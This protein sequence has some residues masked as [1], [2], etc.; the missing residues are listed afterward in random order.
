M[1]LI[2]SGNGRVGRLVASALVQQGDSVRVFVRDE[3]GARS[4]FGVAAQIC[5]GDL[6]D[7]ASLT[8]AMAGVDSVLLCTPVS[9]DMVRQQRAVINAAV[10][11]SKPYLVK[12]SGLAT[13]PGSFVDSGRWHAEIEA[14]LADSGLGYTCL[15]P[16]FFMQN[17][18]FQ[19][20]QVRS[21]GVLRSG[22]PTAPI[23]MVDAR[24]IAAVAVK[25]LCDP[26]LAPGQTLPLTT[27]TALTYAAMAQIMSSVLGQAVRYE[28]QDMAQIEHN[29]RQADQPE[30]HIQLLLQFNQA[31]NQ[32]LA[33]KADE[34]MQQLLG[35]KPLSLKDYLTSVGTDNQGLNPFPS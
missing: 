23:A 34:S 12:V 16:Y 7:P 5:K 9:P 18:G 13:F 15:H 10:N 14:D 2:I 30:W 3:A 25:L 31:F 1:H 32:G 20:A 22:V 26:V 6:D 17:L 27:T 35:R 28:P 33:S 24:D 11:A 19:L 4:R 29:L 8:A 21:S